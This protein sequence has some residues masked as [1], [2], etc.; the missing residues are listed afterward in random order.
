MN[1]GEVIAGSGHQRA[2]AGVEGDNPE[3]LLLAFLTEGIDVLKGFLEQS[4]N[5]ED[6]SFERLAGTGKCLA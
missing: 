3:V 6:G 4:C 1:R 5:R 2:C